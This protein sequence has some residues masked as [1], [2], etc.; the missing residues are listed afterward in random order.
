MN[1]DPRNH[2]FLALHAVENVNMNGHT[3]HPLGQLFSIARNADASKVSGMLTYCER[4][5]TLN[6]PAVATRFSLFILGT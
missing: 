1:T 2:I 6:V 3:L 4:K 5:P